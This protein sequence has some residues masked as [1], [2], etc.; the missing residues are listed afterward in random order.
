MQTMLEQ[1]IHSVIQEMQAS[2]LPL[3]HLTSRRNVEQILKTGLKINSENALT[4]QAFEPWMRTMYK[5][6]KP[7]FLMTD[8][9]VLMKKYNYDRKFDVILRIDGPINIVA[10]I[11]SLMDYGAHVEEHSIWFEDAPAELQEYLQ[12]EEIYFDELFEDDGIIKACMKIT[13][14]CAC[15]NDIPAQYVRV[16]HMEQSGF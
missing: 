6:V 5:S 13:K 11:P 7:I 8:T 4:T 3:Y 16:L 10:D 14:S 15:V 2:N 9:Q 12:G 1:F